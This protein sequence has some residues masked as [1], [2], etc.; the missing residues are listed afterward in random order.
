M[1]KFVGGLFGALVIVIGVAAG[2]LG[3]RVATERRQAPESVAAILR[4]AD[5]AID[6]ITPERLAWLIRVEDPTFWTNN[7]IDQKTPGAGR[8]TIAQGLGKKIFFRRF[9]PGPLKFGKLEVM[10]LTRYALEPTVSKRDILR[11]ALA[12]AYL[13]HK[14]NG[15]V[16]GFAAGA[17]AWFGKAL[18]ALS[19]DEFLT[20]VA[21]LPA[22]NHFTPGGAE[23]RERVARIHR[24]LAGLCAPQSLD[25]IYYENCAASAEAAN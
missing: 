22:P 4:S 9:S 14:G 24:F 11:A 19:D 12:S 7:G 5:P 15:S 23:S 6:A 16:I 20:L 3:F 1:L 10:V 18:P 13:G 8:T 17:K 21:M 25:D 2:Y